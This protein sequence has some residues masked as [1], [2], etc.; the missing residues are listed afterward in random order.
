MK[1]AGLLFVVLGVLISGCTT[2]HKS[3]E[4]YGSD[5]MYG[6][7]LSADMPLSDVDGAQAD[8]VQ[9]EQML[10]W[11]GSI[12]LE[13]YNL[14]NSASLIKAKV[15]EVGGYVES[16]S[17]NDGNSGY[18]PAGTPSVTMKLRVPS[19]KLDEVLGDVEGMGKVIS[20][21]L[22]SEDVTER[23][24]DI[25]ARLNTKKELRDRLKKLLDK[26]VDVKDVLA[27]EKEFNRIQSDIDS[28]EARLKSMKGKV[29]YASLAVTLQ[30]KKPEPIV[31]E[32][33]PGPIG[34]L[35]N[36]TV[37]CV[38][39]L[40]V[41][42]EAEVIEPEVTG[43]GSPAIEHILYPGE[44]MEDVARQYGVSVESIRK[45]NGLGKKGSAK[46]GQ[47]IMVPVSE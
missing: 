11:T 21:T 33:I 15:K 30:V 1:Y 6:D 12:T 3:A 36:G 34:Y 40:F 41:W 27:I 25:Q 26:A 9:S 39:K 31:V 24:V 32:E 44:T 2:S 7:E 23:Y 43:L 10:I 28:M 42:R 37:W 4:M 18:Y 5:N 35:W 19:D 13:I 14:T 8:P 29:D 38:K 47:T 16:S 45:L 46:E 17:Y 22:S 20:K